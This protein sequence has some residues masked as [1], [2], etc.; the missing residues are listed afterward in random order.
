MLPLTSGPVQPRDPV[1]S[2]VL[3]KPAG[4]DCNLRCTYCFYLDRQQRYR[5]AR[6]R[7][8][9]EVLETLIA[10]VMAAGAP[11][12]TFG[13]QGG[14]PTLMGLEF[15]RHA[16][17]L[18]M[19][20]G[21]PL[22]QVANGLQTNGLLLDA[23]WCRFLS[24]CRFLVGLSIDGDEVLHDTHRRDRKGGGSWARVRE[25]AALLRAHE[26]DTNAVV[27][28]SANS[29]GRADEIWE[30]LHGLGLR[31]FQFIPCLEWRDE[32]RLQW[33]DHAL[34]PHDYGALLC[35]FFDLWR[36]DFSGGVPS[37][38]VRTFE[39][40]LFGYVGRPVPLC[41]FAPTCGEDLVVEHNG[42]VFS[43]DFFVDD[44]H[45]LGNLMQTPLTALLADPRQRRF[46]AAKAD[47]PAPCLPCPWRSHCHGG[48]PKDRARA[49]SGDGLNPY[50]GAYRAFFAHADPELRR[51]AD[52]LG[53]PQGA[54][55]PASMPSEQAADAG[56][57]G[58]R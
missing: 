57:T 58:D 56:R 42:D 21:G 47:L 43:C 24:A 23:P 3:V 10:Q 4:A 32:R 22:R 38:F 16:V 54:P 26:V 35:R 25:S 53:R 17:R 51:L 27:L 44:D 40:L 9:P 30:A 29:A 28:L 11:A 19:D 39:A 5:T 8:S 50:C 33:A 2:Q 12:V 46:G 15:F 37:T 6:R 41:Q 55:V 1:L 45:H 13:W 18:Q 49:R 48:C 52:A 7:M 36:A 31:H 34:R 20:R 14:E